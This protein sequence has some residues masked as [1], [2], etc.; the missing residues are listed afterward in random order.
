MGSEIAVDFVIDNPSRARSLIAVGP[1][2]KEY[3]SDSPEFEV[4]MA[5]F[6][7]FG[8]VL[9]QVGPEGAADAWSELPFWVETVCKSDA[10]MKFKQIASEQS[11]IDWT[12]ASQQ[13][14]LDPGAL[15]RLSEIRLPTLI[16][17]AEHDVPA[18][19]EVADLLALRVPDSIKI[20]I[21]GTGHC[22]HMEKP[23]EFNSL[24]LDFLRT[25]KS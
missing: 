16:I 4:F 8:A 12:P 9:E 15:E 6:G 5:Q 21:P 10:G 2:I 3:K 24:V 20:V 11:W 14:M 13:H 1:W 19:V 17:T 25:I 23:D 18:C 22:M 7:S